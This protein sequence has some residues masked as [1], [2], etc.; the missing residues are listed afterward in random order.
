MKLADAPLED[1]LDERVARREV[2]VERADADARA[3]RDLLER[4]LDAPLGEHLAG[5]GDEQLVVAP[6]VA[7][8]PC[9]LSRDAAHA[10]SIHH[11]GG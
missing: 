6:R 3:A 2:P 8:L 11:T 4:G 10:S 9:L 7:P 5:R 1:R